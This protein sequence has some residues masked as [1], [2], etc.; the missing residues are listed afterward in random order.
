MF[1]NGLLSALGMMFT[2]K[3]L[4]L[5]FPIATYT[6]CQLVHVMVGQAKLAVHL[7]RRNRM[8]QKP[9]HDVVPILW[10]LL[11]SNMSLD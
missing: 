6:K 3:S 4:V 1:L 10:N 5:P 11:R 9:G 8:R 2:K 7:S